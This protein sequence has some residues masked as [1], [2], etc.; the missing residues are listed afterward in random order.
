MT[1]REKGEERSKMPNT[2][3]NN[4]SM[5]RP[6]IRKMLREKTAGVFYSEHYNSRKWDVAGVWLTTLQCHQLLSLISFLLVTIEWG[7]SYAICQPL[8][9]VPCM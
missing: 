7:P 4:N 8:G 9:L 6:K 3:E 2:L 5:R 1:K